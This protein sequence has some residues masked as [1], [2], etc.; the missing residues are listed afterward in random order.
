M[1]RTIAIERKQL[2]VLRGRL[3]DARRRELGLKVDDLAK[4]AGT[5]YGTTE[6]ALH[7]RPIGAEW[8]EPICAALGLTVAESTATADELRPASGCSPEAMAHFRREC[9]RRIEEAI[10]E[11]WQETDTEAKRRLW[12]WPAFTTIRQTVSLKFNTASE[13]A[14]A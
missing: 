5:S 11:A 9:D 8:S 4:K 10:R 7:G 6:R 1:V 3:L 13:G 2:T 14:S 12:Y